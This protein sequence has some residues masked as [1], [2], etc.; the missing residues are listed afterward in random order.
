MIIFENIVNNLLPVLLPVI[1]PL[2]L[3][4]FFLKINSSRWCDRLIWSHDATMRL[5]QQDSLLI[6]FLMVLLNLSLVVV[7]GKQMFVLI[8][9]RGFCPKKKVRIKFSK[10]QFCKDQKRS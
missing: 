2:N 6:L 9:N 4:F 3:I 7:D 5:F 1:I 10:S 8:E